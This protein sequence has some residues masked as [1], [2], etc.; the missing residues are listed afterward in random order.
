MALDDKQ[1]DGL[2][3]ATS[4]VNDLKA[5]SLDI[6]ETLLDIQDHYGIEIPDK[7]AQKMT[8][9]GDLVKYISAHPNYKKDDDTKPYK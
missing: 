8:C 1:R 7:E 6:I 9:I 2:T 5:D 4:L 3:P